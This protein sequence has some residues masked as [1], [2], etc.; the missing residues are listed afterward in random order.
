MRLITGRSEQEGGGGEEPGASQSTEVEI[1]SSCIN[2]QTPSTAPPPPLFLSPY[3]PFKH[4]D[5][6]LQ[7][8]RKSPTSA[9]AQLGRSLAQH[10]VRGGWPAAIYSLQWMHIA[11]HCRGEWVGVKANVERRRRVAMHCCTRFIFPTLSS[12]HEQP[13]PSCPGGHPAPD[14][15]NHQQLHPLHFQE[16]PPPAISTS[17]PSTHVMNTKSETSPLLT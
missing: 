5:P 14:P 6:R 2:S 15:L 7:S 10:P 16:H 12:F 4:P 3:H 1:G 9:A 11:M 17:T 8:L 13:P